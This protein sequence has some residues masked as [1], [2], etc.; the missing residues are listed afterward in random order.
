MLF[1]PKCVAGVTSLA[2]GQ[3]G[4]RPLHCVR[5]RQFKGDDWR[6]DATNGRALGIVRGPSSPGPLELAAARALPAP[7]S[8]VLESLISA[9]DLAKFGR[10]YVRNGDWDGT[11]IIPSDWV[12]TSTTEG[13]YSPDEWPADLSLIWNYKHQWWL[14]SEDGA[15]STLG[16]DGQYLYIDPQK[17]LIIV[18]LGV[19]SADLPWL[20]IFQQIAQEIQ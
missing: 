11:Q 20:Q 15:Y 13:A 6:I 7:E 19:E 10:L 2:A 3:G 16:K 8:L 17:N 4:R 1:L 12:I 5:V 14:L 18:R 9:R